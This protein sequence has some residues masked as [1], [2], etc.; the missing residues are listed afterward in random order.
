MQ[1]P[2]WSKTFTLPPTKQRDRF[3]QVFSQPP[4]LIERFCKRALRL[5]RVQTKHLYRYRGVLLPN[6]NTESSLIITDFN[7]RIT[8]MKCRMLS[9]LF[10]VI[11]FKLP[12]AKNETYKRLASILLFAIPNIAHT[13]WAKLRVRTACTREISTRNLSLPASASLIRGR[14]RHLY[15][16]CR[17]DRM[18]TSFL[19]SA[20]MTFTST[21]SPRL[22]KSR[23]SLTGRLET[24]PLGTKP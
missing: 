21:R 9:T 16:H 24:C 7:C 18:S 17:I 6:G 10:R 12:P 22:T 23:T 15:P 14:T 5:C 4:F 20:L 3:L 13:P 19:R 2:Q 8:P 1:I 11:R